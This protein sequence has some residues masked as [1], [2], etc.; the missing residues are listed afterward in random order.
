MKTPKKVSG[1]QA[2]EKKKLKQKISMH[3][4]DLFVVKRYLNIVRNV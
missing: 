4:A 3:Y 1:M 2:S